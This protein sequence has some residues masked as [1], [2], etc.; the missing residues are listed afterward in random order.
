MECIRKAQRPASQW[1]CLRRDANHGRTLSNRQ[2]RDARRLPPLRL[3]EY[4]SI[5][6]ISRLAV[7][8]VR[9]RGS[10]FPTSSFASSAR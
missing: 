2:E 6:S 5:A 9:A 8:F 4:K 3:E 10:A 1:L 7:R